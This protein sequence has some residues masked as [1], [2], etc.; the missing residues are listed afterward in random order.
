MNEPAVP[1]TMPR[2]CTSDQFLQVIV[3]MPS[4]ATSHT[5]PLGA[6]DQAPTPARSNNTP[7]SLNRKTMVHPSTMVDR[8]TRLPFALSLTIRVEQPL[9]RL[10]VRDR[11]RQH[12]RRPIGALDHQPP[13][14]KR[15]LRAGL[16]HVP[17]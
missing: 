10:G 3:T 5:T 1:M 13:P 12:P 15:E 2:A 16:D 17:Q 6:R 8:L 11:L 4:R 9:E 7:G 14:A